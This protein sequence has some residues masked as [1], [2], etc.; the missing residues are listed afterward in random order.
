MKAGLQKPTGKTREAGATHS[1]F[2]E[3]AEP[4]K[5]NLNGFDGEVHQPD[6][7][8]CTSADPPPMHKLDTATSLEDKQTIPRCRLL[9]LPAELR[10]KIYEYALY[11]KE[12]IAVTT[13]LT[14]PSL[15]ETCHMIRKEARSMWYT[16]NNFTI[17]IVDLDF[18][19]E[20]SWTRHV[21]ASTPNNDHKLVPI[22]L[23]F[24]GRI[25]SKGILDWCKDVHSG[26]GCILVRSENPRKYAARQW[27]EAYA[28]MVASHVIVRTHRR[29][30]WETCQEA[31][32]ALHFAVAA[33]KP[34][35]LKI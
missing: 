26:N 7:R 8:R 14:E 24:Q 2:A 10:N 29:S 12:K 17:N 9:E 23:I 27:E 21:K 19:L 31:L 28:L 22:T 33:T 35:W 18:T 1:V 15:L 11:A 16:S 34:S 13:S 32:E 5:K 4:M 3:H 20:R 6:E 25:T 30:S